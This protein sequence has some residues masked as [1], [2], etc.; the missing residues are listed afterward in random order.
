[1]DGNITQDC[2]KIYN[3]KVEHNIPKKYIVIELLADPGIGERSIDLILPQ[4]Q[5]IDLFKL[6]LNGDISKVLRVKG[7]D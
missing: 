5:V 1:M 7:F 3:I 2:E 6:I 4:S